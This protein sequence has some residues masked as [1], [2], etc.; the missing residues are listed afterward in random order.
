[1]KNGF[2]RFKQKRQHPTNANTHYSIYIYHFGQLDPTALVA[3]VIFFS[4]TYYE[5]EYK[6]VSLLY[7]KLR[8]VLYLRKLF[9]TG[10]AY[11]VALS[12]LRGTQ[13]RPVTTLNARVRVPPTPVACV[14]EV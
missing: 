11:F 13:P 3:Y 4:E 14:L 8:F 2:V 1:M 12:L 6:I 9:S 10:T 5:Y 7:V